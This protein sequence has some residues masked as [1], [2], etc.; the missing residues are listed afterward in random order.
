VAKG[1][2]VAKAAPNASTKAIVEKIILTFFIKFK[3]S[4]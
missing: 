1:F 2:D 4:F 3:F